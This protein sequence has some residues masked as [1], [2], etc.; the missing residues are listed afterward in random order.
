MLF[1]AGNN[2]PIADLLRGYLIHRI[3][4]YL[5]FNAGDIDNRPI[6][7]FLVHH[8]L[9][10]CLHYQVCSLHKSIHVKVKCIDRQDDNNNIIM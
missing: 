9:G 8:E 5:C 3:M 1:N 7:G 2:Q 6:A 4:Q 10:G